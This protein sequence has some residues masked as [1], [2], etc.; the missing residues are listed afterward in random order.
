MQYQLFPMKKL[1]F[2][3]L[4]LITLAPLLSWGIKKK[5]RRQNNSPILSVSMQRTGCYGKCPEYKIEMDKNGNVTYTGI[6]NVKDSGVYKKNIGYPATMA[7]INKLNENKIDT[8]SNKYRNPIPDLPGIIY[9][10]TY[11]DSVKRIFSAEWGPHYLK[12]TAEEIDA[13]G[14]PTNKTWKKVRA[15]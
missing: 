4:V 2:L 12:E 14:K 10:V 15:K 7:I 1:T 6:R 11:K 13:I 5:K 8:C 9:T 3:A